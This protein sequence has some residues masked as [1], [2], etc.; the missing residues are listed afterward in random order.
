MFI[1]SKP[2]IS[3]LDIS[4][5]LIYSALQR[6]CPHCPL[7]SVWR[8]GRSKGTGTMLLYLAAL[9]ALHG[10]AEVRPHVTLRG[11]SLYYIEDTTDYKI[12]HSVCH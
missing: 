4:S 9:C 1:C 3:S 11:R 10:A 12:H 7:G 8:R 6:S 2:D 5:K